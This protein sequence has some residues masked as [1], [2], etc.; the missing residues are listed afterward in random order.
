MTHTK[1]V[2]ASTQAISPG[3]YTTVFGGDS[4]E[5]TTREPAAGHIIKTDRGQTGAELTVIECDVD[6]TSGRGRKMVISPV[7]ET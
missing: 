4:S 7:H 3:L 6:H 5:E 1:A 2:D